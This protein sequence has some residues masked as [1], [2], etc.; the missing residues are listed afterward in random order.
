MALNLEDELVIPD[1]IDSIA[2]D[3]LA[4]LFA[5]N[6]WYTAQLDFNLRTGVVV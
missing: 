1:W 4:L 6:S 5:T 2:R 3:D